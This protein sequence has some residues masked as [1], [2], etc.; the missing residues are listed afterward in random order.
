MMT[1]EPIPPRLRRQVSD[2][3]TRI[4]ELEEALLKVANRQLVIQAKQLEVLGQ[5]AGVPVT[6]QLKIGDIGFTT[7]AIK[8]GEI[9]TAW[10]NGL[11]FEVMALEEIDIRK[12]IIVVDLPNFVLEYTSVKQP[13]VFVRTKAE[14]DLSAGALSKTTELVTKFRLVAVLVHLSAAVSPTIT[15]TLDSKDGAVYDAVIDKQTLSSNTDYALLGGEGELEYEDG[16]QIRVDIT[17][18]S[19]TAGLTIITEEVP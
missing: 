15:V 1:E 13:R 2:I 8:K 6:A 4:D 7:D 3:F 17:S 9:G 14:H 16:D 11:Q 18:V 10:F 5:I 12:E 19:A